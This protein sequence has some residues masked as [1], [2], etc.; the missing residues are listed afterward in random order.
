[1]TAAALSRLGVGLW[2]MQSTA[3]A[4]AQPTAL[5]RAFAEDAQLVERLGFH[6]VWTAEHRAWYD[7]WCPALMHAQAFAAARTSR[8]R[9]GNAMLLLPQHDPVRMARAVATLD[10]LSGGRVDLGAGLGHRDAEY[11]ALG[12]RRDRRGRRMDEA[13][14]TLARV[15]SGELGD[16]P[17]VQRPGPPIWIGGM[18]PPA[19]ARAARHGHGLM[20]PQTL[21]PHEL[22][23]IA[24]DYRGQAATPGPVG[25]LRDVWIEPDAARERRFRA[26]VDRHFR[27][28]AGSWWVLKGQ[29]GFSQPEQ[30]TR[31]LQRIYDTEVIGSAERVAQELNALFAAGADF[32]ALR[33][34]FDF[35]ERPALH[36]QI[37]RLAEEVAPLL[38]VPAA[39]PAR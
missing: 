34:N 27:E 28:E 21:R 17:P 31:Q 14:E 22:R 33:L 3:V 12:L 19:V 16:E 26:R 13:L 23:E 9:F 2:T 35:V 29:V 10:R 5:Y 20:L 4:P 38:E 18:A 6:S 39:A 15:W 25:A 24:E 37:A 32:L 8:V 11:D 30:L 1:M 36:E 7:G